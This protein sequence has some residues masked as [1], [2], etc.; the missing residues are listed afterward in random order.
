MIAPPILPNLLAIGTGGVFFVILLLFAVASWRERERR[1][2]GVALALAFVTPL[3]YLIAGLWAFPGQPA[4][5]GM[6]LVLTALGVLL[7]AAPTGRRPQEPEIPKK[8]VDE[9]DIMFA[10][11]K[12]IPG[13][14]EYADYYR[15]HPEREAQDN[16]FR[17]A[18]GL[19]APGSKEYHPFLSLATEAGFAAIDQLQ[20][21]V[22][23]PPATKQTPV[24][25]AAITR[26]LKGLALHYGAA[27]VGVTGLR[28]YHVYTHVGRG[29]G[30]Y[31]APVELNHRYAVA[32][33]V[34]MSYDMLRHA[35]T[36][37]EVLEVATGYLS[38]GVV[39]VQL[40]T[41][42]RALG[43]PARAHIDGNYRVICPLVARDAGL[44]EI[45]RMGILMTPRQGPRVRIAVVTT[46][47]PLV[48]DRP[49][50]DPSAIDFCRICR[51]CAK[52]C[53][54]QSI[55]HGDRQMIDGASRW[56]INSDSC[57]LYWNVVG[58]DCG[59]CIAVC[60]YSHPDSP[61]HG[62]VRWAIRRSPAAR[63]LALRMDD[64]FYGRKPSALAWPSWM[65]QRR[66]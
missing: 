65:G 44:G 32:V 18:P 38:A 47:L 5:A 31:G 16:R 49:H 13:R 42:I 66:A 30:A 26:F 3:P 11:W 61:F 22:D 2:A 17:R 57:F 52:N 51:K 48:P 20:G 8:R 15:R 25:P 10:R 37:P 36:A 35:P 24:E 41:F 45:G 12:L 29:A 21:T 9:R 7:L 55:P 34:E 23:G 63:W 6:L 27:D 62:A 59:R 46:D 54:S 28:D 56:R 14:P 33:T 58:T 4:V 43:Y 39:A 19:L 40:A 64:L 60:P 1:A 53:P 50:G